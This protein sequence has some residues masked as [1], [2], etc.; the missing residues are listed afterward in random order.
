MATQLIT[1]AELEDY[2][3]TAEL[4]R[5]SDKT[6]TAINVA[7]VE[8]AIEMASST[9][10]KFAQ[11]TPGYPWSET[12]QEAKTICMQLA[13]YYV[14]QGNW[15]FVPPD[16]KEGFKEAMAELQEL[17]NGNTSWVD[18]QVPAVQNRS[19]VFY[20]NSIDKPR[21]GAPVRARRY[22]TDKL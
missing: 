18:G 7:L 19:E 1:Q 5:A 3:T 6:N 16:R 22:F 14:F 2:V 10:L 11:G 13:I 20:T 15:G 21:E 4:K 9:I 8:N 12:P 17:K